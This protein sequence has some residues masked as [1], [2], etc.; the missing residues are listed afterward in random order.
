[1]GSNRPTEKRPSEAWPW[2]LVE[3]FLALSNQ[4]ITLA[5]SITKVALSALATSSAR[6]VVER[7]MD[8]PPAQASG[9]ARR[10][11]ATRKPRLPQI[12]LGPELHLI[13]YNQSEVFLWFH[14][15]PS[16][17]NLPLELR[18]THLVSRKE[19]R[20]LVLAP[21]EVSLYLPAP[22]QSGVHRIAIGFATEGAWTQL[23]DSV[24]IR[25]RGS[26]TTGLIP[27]EPEVP[28]S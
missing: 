7:T 20:R 10:D 19:T 11:G 15:P 27:A 13:S 26:A 1:M 5:E 12:P 28:N 8:A 18:E 23:S 25:G 16:D 22:E 21:G 24:E 6:S 9:V 14:L 3:P 2:S 4:V 17:A